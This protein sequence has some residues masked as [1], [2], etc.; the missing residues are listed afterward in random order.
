MAPPLA[1]HL[2]SN[3]LKGVRQGDFGK[4]IMRASIF[5]NKH[6]VGCLVLFCVQFFMG[7][8]SLVKKEP[9]P[10]PFFPKVSGIFLEDLKN[11]ANAIESVTVTGRLELKSGLKRLPSVRI[12]A[13]Y[14]KRHEASFLRIKAFASFSITVFD[15]LSKNGHCWIYLPRAGKVYEGSTFF[16]NYGKIGVRAATDL[17]GIILNPWSPARELRL[18]EQDCFKN[19]GLR[20]FRA[21]FIGQEMV[22]EYFND[23]SPRSFHSKDVT[24]SFHQKKAHGFPDRISFSIEK[25]GIVGTISISDYKINTIKPDSLLFHEDFFLKKLLESKY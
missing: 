3:S 22:F 19:H 4:G 6:I 11:R 20:C 16:T 8:C 15:L 24:I 25:A 1:F 17:I 12:K 23:L 14:L 9:S 18:F 10:W 2:K 5:I 21:R 7:A 13:W